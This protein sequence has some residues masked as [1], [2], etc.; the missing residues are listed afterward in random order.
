VTTSAMGFYNCACCGR[1]FQARK[2]DRAR[3]WAVYCS[4]SCKALAQVRRQ[5][6]AARQSKSIIRPRRE[7]T[8]EAWECAELMARR[9]FPHLFD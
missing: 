7:E 5:A 8:N 3:G 9:M 1:R 2:V 6:Q 4:K